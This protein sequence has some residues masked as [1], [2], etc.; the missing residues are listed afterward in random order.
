M[1]G[2]QISLNSVVFTPINVD[3]DG[4]KMGDPLGPMADGSRGFAHRANK[5]TWRISWKRVPSS[6]RAS[7]RSIFTLT[8]SFP[9]VD[10]DGVSATVYCPPGGF[11]SRIAVI[12]A[13]I[14]LYYDVQ[15]TIEEV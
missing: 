13:G 11:R 10:E 12:A 5:R 2:K 15:L 3:E 8:S 14:V 6:V 9:F 4:D 7:I 1:A